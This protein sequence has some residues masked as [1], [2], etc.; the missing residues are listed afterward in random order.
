MGDRGADSAYRR[1]LPAIAAM[2]LVGALIG[3][4]MLVTRARDSVRGPQV[5][6]LGTGP[7]VVLLR[8]F[9]EV[10]DQPFTASVAVDL[11]IDPVRLVLQ[12]RTAVAAEAVSRRG[13]DAD[14]LVANSLAPGL[15]AARD[16]TGELSP[17]VVE[18]VAERTLGDGVS[19]L[20]LVDADRDG[21]DDDGSFSVV[22][23]DGSA[24]CVSIGD[25][26]ALATALLLAV[27]PIDDRP[28]SGVTW[29]PHG[30]CGLVAE[31]PAGTE[32]R[33]GTTPGTYGGTDASDVCDPGLLVERLSASRLVRESWA[34]AQSIDVGS[35]EEFVDDLTPVVL[36]R[37]TLATEYGFDRGRVH[38]LQ[39]VLQR[40]TTV[41]IDWTG[42]PRV[43]CLSGAPLGPPRAVLSDEANVVGEPWRGFTIDAVAR[44]RAAE[45]AT[46]RLV[47]VDIR[48]GEPIIREQVTD[49]QDA[50]APL[51][52]AL[53]GG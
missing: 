10:G 17:R 26:R 24:V 11:G 20:G 8:G 49:S 42:Q 36:L 43:R 40:G 30:S 29:T 27:D 34:A 13:S 41:M 18:G 32:V 7:G 6:V 48:S 1:I 12:P 50:G 14:R 37:D 28:A 47:L 35:V 3:G 44:V 19:L 53:E 25:R 38:T 21:A 23:P 46:S 9:D 31:P 52:G 22:A 5:D 33:V 51:V 45:V 39:V 15:V 4:I 16:E 2:T